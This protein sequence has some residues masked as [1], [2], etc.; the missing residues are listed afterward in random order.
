MKLP[1]VV[2]RRLLLSMLL[3]VL[4]IAAIDFPLR[5]MSLRDSRPRAFSPPD[6]QPIAKPTNKL[7]IDEQLKN[8]FPKPPEPEVP[9][10]RSVSLGGVFTIGG[11]AR[12]MIQLGP[13][14]DLPAQYVTVGSTELVIDGWVVEVIE[15]QRV[16]LRRNSETRELTVFRTP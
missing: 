15:G 8:W 6:L 5:I 7:E 13:F 16:V 14:G 9:P 2:S 3:L 10:E 11:Q 4:I 1:I 12:A